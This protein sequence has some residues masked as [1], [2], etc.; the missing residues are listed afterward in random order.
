MTTQSPAAVAA[1]TPDTGAIATLHRPVVRVLAAVA[2][3][4]FTV[5]IHYEV[6]YRFEPAGGSVTSLGTL[7]IGDRAPAF[8]ALDLEGATV[9]LAAFQGRKAVLIEFWATWCPPC[10]MI[11]ATL[12]SMAKTLEEH[13]V[14]VLSVNQGESA[15]HVREYVKRE[16]APFHVV[17]DP[18]A[19]VSRQYQVSTLPTMFLVDRRGIIRWIRVGHMPET[20]ELRELLDRIAAE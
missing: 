20:E 15:E 3:A 9:D 16:G 6:K 7:A 10:R 18:D 12:R 4:V 11:L 19:E 17:L 13:G 14:E 8:R 2:F 5:W 1:E